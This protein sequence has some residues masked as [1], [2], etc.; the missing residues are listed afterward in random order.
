MEYERVLFLG[1]SPAVA[2][3]ALVAR[4]QCL[5]ELG[6]YADALD[7]LERVRLFALS[8]EDAAKVH[9]LQGI[10]HYH[11]GDYE[12][13]ASF[14]AEGFPDTPQAGVYSVLILAGARRYDESLSKALDIYP[15]KEARLRELFSEAPFRKK[16][17]TATMLSLLPPLGHIY[18]G[19]KDWPGITALSY[20][21]MAFTAWQLIEGNWL[22]GILGGGLFL[23]ATYMEHNISTMAERTARA[24]EKSLGLFLERLEAEVL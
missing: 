16:E 11:S 22:T 6:R 5:L 13:A 15:D 14:M 24:N 1:A 18:L 7:A 3:E 20:A 19:E 2:N 4:A 12:G 17:G 21:G 10:S 8:A 9:L 23:N